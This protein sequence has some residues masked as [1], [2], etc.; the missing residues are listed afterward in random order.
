MGCLMESCG[1]I[2]RYLVSVLGRRD[3]IQR[4]SLIV[5]RKTDPNSLVN[6]TPF[7]LLPSLGRSTCVVPLA[8][9]L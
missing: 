2:L 3:V 7:F 4:C 9:T 8:M 1:V 5:Q 6:V